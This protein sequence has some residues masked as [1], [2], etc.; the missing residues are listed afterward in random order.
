MSTYV[1]LPLDQFGRELR[2]IVA[3]HC[4]VP[5]LGRLVVVHAVAPAI[6]DHLHGVD[7][8]DP[9]VELAASPRSPSVSGA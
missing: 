1:L 3:G 2:A 9:T 6:V 5:V 4:Q 8:A 7:R